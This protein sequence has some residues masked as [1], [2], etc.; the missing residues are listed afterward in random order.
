M[1]QKKT[2]RSVL[3]KPGAAGARSGRR[4]PAI[5]PFAIFVCSKMNIRPGL[6]ALQFS[7]GSMQG[8]QP[9]PPYLHPSTGWL[10]MKGLGIGIDKKN[11]S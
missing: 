4:Q 9:K 2:A 3:K 11:V 5:G 10:G 6:R 7:L 8:R 1:T